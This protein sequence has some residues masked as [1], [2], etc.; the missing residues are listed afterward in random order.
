MIGGR[1]R[2]L[3]VSGFEQIAQIVAV[4]LC[5]FDAFD[6]CL[7]LNIEG[8]IFR[9]LGVGS[10]IFPQRLATIRVPIFAAWHRYGPERQC[11]GCVGIDRDTLNEH[12]ARIGVP[13][14]PVGVSFDVPVNVSAW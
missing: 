13:D 6:F 12:A 3:V 8:G 2:C 7:L 14:V 11:T 4:I 1:F 5:R 9:L 10:R